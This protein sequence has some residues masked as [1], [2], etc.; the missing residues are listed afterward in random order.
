M[1]GFD[2]D[3][4]ARLRELIIWRRDVRRFRTE[5]LAPGTVDRLLDLAALAPSVGLS[6]PW[7]FVLVDSI[8]RRAAVRAEFCRCN[9]AALDCYAGERARL[10]ATLKLAGLDE[11]PVQLAVFTDRGTTQG[12]GLGRRTMPETAEYSVVMAIHTLWLAARAERIGLGW[13]SILDPVVM[14]RLLDVPAEWIFLGYFCLGY[15]QQE[16]TTPELERE[17][18]E[19]RRASAE[20]ILRR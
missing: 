12:H 7:R 3:F 15:P 2:D 20:F 10:Y 6:Q 1:T 14:A 9:A 13:V 19:K 4:R 18:W 16:E 11:A 5:P 8:E 17:G